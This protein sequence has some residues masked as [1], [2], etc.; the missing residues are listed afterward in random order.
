MKWKWL[1]IVVAGVLVG[2]ETRGE[3]AGGRDLEQLQGAWKMVSHLFN[4]EP[5]EGL[6]DVV[7]IVEG[8]KFIIKRGEQVLRGGTMKLD[9]TRKPKWID[10]VFTEGPEK[11]RTRR[12]IYVLEGDRQTICYGELDKD[13]PTEFL[14]E[15]GSGHRLVVFER[16]GQ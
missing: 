2:A 16:A 15:R 12:G 10:I 13:R 5:D 11:G 7:R 1:T 3:P 4:G 14:S 8:D 6:K 9:P